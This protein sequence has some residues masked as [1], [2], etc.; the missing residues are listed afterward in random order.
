MAIIARLLQSLPLVIFLAVLAVVIY[1][2]VSWVRTP[3]RAKEVLIRVFTIL[4]I[5]LSAFFLLAS[6]YAFF[7]HNQPVLELTVS[8]LVV[9][10]VALGITR[11]CR[12]RFV[13]NNPHYVD[14]SQKTSY[15]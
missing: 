13:K 4:N 14:K 15:L 3:Q 2:F 1:F 5:V 8:F 11:I 7:E 9:A 6:A 10:L 12:W